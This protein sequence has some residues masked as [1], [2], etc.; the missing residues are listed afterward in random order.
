MRPNFLIA[1]FLV[2]MLDSML[3]L[4]LSIVT[5]LSAKNLMIYLAFMMIV[6][7]YAIRGGDLLRPLFAI[8]GLWILII[9]LAIFSWLTVSLTGLHPGYSLMQG[10]A[11]LKNQMLD[12]FLFL[13]VFAFMLRDS[14]ECIRVARWLLLIFGLANFI[15]LLDTFNLPDLGIVESTADS[16]VTGPLGEENQYG[17]ALAFFLPA[18]IGMALASEGF[19]RKMLWGSALVAAVML[20]LTVSR[21]SFLGLAV[22]GG[23][24][25]W[26]A[27]A[28]LKP[29][30]LARGIGVGFVVILVAGIAV[31]LNDPDAF[32]ARFQFG[33][34]VT[35]DRVSSGRLFRWMTV[36]EFMSQNPVSF[37][38]GYGWNTFRLYLSAFGDP[39]NIY[40]HYLWN[41]GLIG[42]IPF[43][44]LHW[45][46]MRTTQRSL[47]PAGESERMVLMGFLTGWGALMA[48]LFFVLLFVPWLFIWAY[49][50]VAL[51]LVSDSL[52]GRLNA[53]AV[54]S[55]S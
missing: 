54:E 49:A 5:G 7:E 19:M 35:I 50:G 14:S 10:A 16:R 32:L 45:N 28:Y 20:V 6:L 48:C 12:H 9:S 26:L 53:D 2:L 52:S 8:F 17:T 23:F 51:R 33:G 39:H 34:P 24:G 55:P 3:G 42:L 36:L 37:I 29:G 4:N 18:T 13:V 44:F 43:C 40:L 27:R 25:L 47:R 15:S 46:I 38:V 30:S 1:V 21:G 31:V 22:G 41:L 11:A